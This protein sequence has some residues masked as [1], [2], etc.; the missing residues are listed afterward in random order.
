MHEVYL[1]IL[2]YTGIYWYILW[3]AVTHHPVLWHLNF[4]P[5]RMFLMFEHAY[6]YLPGTLHCILQSKLKKTTVQTMHQI[7]L[8][9]LVYPSIYWYILC[10][11]YTHHPLL[12]IRPDPPCDSDGSLHHA[13][14]VQRLQCPALLQSA[15]LSALPG[16]SKREAWILALAEHVRDR[17][18]WVTSQK[19]RD[20]RDPAHHVLSRSHVETQRWGWFIQL[21]HPSVLH[22]PLDGQLELF[23][24]TEEHQAAH[25]IIWAGYV[26]L[27]FR[28]SSILWTDNA[29]EEELGTRIPTVFQGNITVILLNVVRIRRD[30]NYSVLHRIEELKQLFTSMN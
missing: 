10:H 1:Y 18:S 7:Y 8:Y 26:G 19:K 2:L 27:V 4:V 25:K 22:R 14:S 24:G 29:G 5:Q 16:A 6:I 15:P 12:W 11:T 9:I 28:L 3:H 20:K 21:D 23:K 13:S 30:Y 17:L